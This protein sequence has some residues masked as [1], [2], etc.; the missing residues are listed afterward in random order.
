MDPVVTR[1]SVPDDD[2]EPVTRPRVS[3]SRVAVTRQLTLTPPRHP[4]TST[5]VMTLL[6]RTRGDRGGGLSIT[7]VCEGS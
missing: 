6:T 3:H 2:L 7:R 4:R 1:L 5:G